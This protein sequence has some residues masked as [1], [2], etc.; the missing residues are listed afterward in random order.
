MYPKILY[1][2][3]G[4]LN[5]L[6]DNIHL[7]SLSSRIQVLLHDIEIDDLVN[8]ISRLFSWL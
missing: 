8:V 6:G 5:L 3:F 2:E 7:G 4:I 1:D